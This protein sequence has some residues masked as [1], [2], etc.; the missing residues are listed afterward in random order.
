MSSKNSKDVT[1]D[2]LKN[3]LGEVQEKYE[4]GK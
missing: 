1:L 4:M 3:Y 2:L